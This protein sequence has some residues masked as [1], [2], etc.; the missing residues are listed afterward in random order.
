MNHC[1]ELHLTRE[2]FG[3]MIASSLRIT[4]GRDSNHIRLGNPYETACNALSMLPG[5][6]VC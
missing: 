5:Q 6:T 2:Y 3:T 1:V 4:V